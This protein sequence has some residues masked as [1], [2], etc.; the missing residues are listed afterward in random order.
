M[1]AMRGATLRLGCSRWSSKGDSSSR[2]FATSTSQAFF[3]G[4]SLDGSALR[5]G[6]PT[7]RQRS[8]TGSLFRSPGRRRN[9]ANLRSARICWPLHASPTMHDPDSAP[10]A[11]IALDA[12]LWDEP[13]TGIGLYAR[14]LYAALQRQGV[15][16]WRIG[17]RHSGD[18]PRG[19]IGRT[20]YFLWKLAEVLQQVE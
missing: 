19:E 15:R 11:S 18:S 9:T 3:P 20:V 16:V 14:N 2:R 8:S 12:S 6:S 7:G 17:A 4:F 10:P 1:W 13:T 5:E